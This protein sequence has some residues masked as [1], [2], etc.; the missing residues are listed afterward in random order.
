M[1]EITGEINGKI[2]NSQ[3][4]SADE[5]CDMFNI[6]LPQSLH[7]EA[8]RVTRKK[9]RFGQERSLNN[10]NAVSNI[11]GMYN[12]S[13][14]NIRYYTSKVDRD[15]STKYIPRNVKIGLPDTVYNT[16]ENK[17]LAVF[18]ILYP[19]CEQSPLRNNRRK[20]YKVKD[21]DREADSI[22]SEKLMLR[23]IED[24]V[25]MENNISLLRRIAYGLK[26]ERKKVPNP[27]DLSINQLKAELLKLFKLNPKEFSNKFDDVTVKIEGLI[28]E[29]KIANVIRLIPQGN[30]KIWEYTSSQEEI[31]RIVNQSPE[32][33][34]LHHLSQPDV[35]KVHYPKMERLI[36]EKGV[37]KIALQQIMDD[38]SQPVEEKE[39]TLDEMDNAQMVD[40]AINSNKIWF[41]ES[42]SRVALMDGMEDLGTLVKVNNKAKWKQELID[43]VNNA[44]ITLNKLKN[45]LK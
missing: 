1:L 25:L 3:I 8:N 5:L 31:V 43:K 37:D 42:N 16:T 20:L 32:L 11:V 26:I 38:V 28:Q 15:N 9:D 12:G 17:E 36:Q 44:S 22:I 24:K 13:Q 40:Y 2:Y 14:I 34:L 27:K 4:V 19:A 35:F 23:K 45:H 39:L 21:K 18:S 41:D 10:I 29:A 30:I 33:G 7:L 6:D